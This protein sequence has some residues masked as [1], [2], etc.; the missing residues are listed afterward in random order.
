MSR[1]NTFYKAK[2]RIKSVNKCLNIN[3]ELESDSLYISLSSAQELDAMH[4]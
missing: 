4:L 2:T 3:L 1:E